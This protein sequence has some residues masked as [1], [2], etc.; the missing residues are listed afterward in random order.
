MA[1]AILIGRILLESLL[2][3]KL[4]AHHA[5]IVS[6]FLELLFVARSHLPCECRESIKPSRKMAFW[7]LCLFSSACKLGIFA[8]V[9]DWIKKHA[10]AMLSKNKRGYEIKTVPFRKRFRAN[11]ADAYLAG[12]LAA[13]RA[14][15]LF[16][17]AQSAG[18]GGI[19]DLV[20]LGE[21]NANKSLQRRLL[22][23]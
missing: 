21:K 15:S 4:S 8:L 20:G 23:K 14:A 2:L 19:E 22:E 10:K 3:E 18:A 1:W 5:S 13:A 6:S 7:E 17:D 12:S 16:I 9:S 11:L